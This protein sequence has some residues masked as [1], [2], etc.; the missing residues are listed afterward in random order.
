MI[1]KASLFN[2]KVLHRLENVN[3]NKITLIGGKN[4][5]GKS[6]LLEALF[7]YMDAKNPYVFN[8]LL[9][10]RGFDKIK[11]EPS[12]LWSPFFSDL[13]TSKKIDFDVTDK[14]GVNRHLQISYQS[15][16][17][18]K[19][20][21]PVNN[22]G[23]LGQGLTS[24]SGF[25]ALSFQHKTNNS[26]DFCAHI[27]LN[28]GGISY[29]TECDTSDLL[30]PV[31]FMGSV[32]LNS[33]ENPELLSRLEKNDEQDKVLPILQ[34]LEPNIQRLQLLKDGQQDVV[35]ADF[36]N[37]RKLPVNLLGAGFCRCLTIALIL[38]TG[39]KEILFIDEIENGIHHSLLSEFWQFLIKASDMYNCQIIAT[40]HSYEMIQA[41][42]ETAKKDHFEDIAYIRL[43]KKDRGIYAYQF[44]SDEITD[45]LASEMEVR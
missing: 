14:K 6:T 1:T 18:P 44:N 2:F 41:F 17:V 32:M 37:K 33:P 39:D 19:I 38:A 25:N 13:D 31:Y 40:T 7:V 43:A 12:L 27:L 15:N 42:S 28:S 21:V 29:Y 11:V 45:A 3:L 20:P 24:S 35:Y 26:T 10:W 36:G 4:N 8:N 23:Y 34:M 9:I 22:N 16:Y 5:A 30:H